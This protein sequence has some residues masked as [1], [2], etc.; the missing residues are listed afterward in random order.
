MRTCEDCVYRD[1]TRCCIDPPHIVG[2]DDKD[3][4]IQRDP[5]IHT[6]RIACKWHMT[7]TQ[8]DCADVIRMT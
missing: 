3:N 8:R 4:P 2:L 6:D 5:T 1:H 7:D